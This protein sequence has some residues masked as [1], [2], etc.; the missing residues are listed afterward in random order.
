MTA[1]ILELGQAV[2]GIR[3]FLASHYGWPGYGTTVVSITGAQQI[4]V[5]G[6]K[7]Q[8][9]EQPMD[10]AMTSA[11]KMLTRQVSAAVRLQA[12]TRGLLARRRVR[13]MRD[14]QLIQPCTPSQLLQVALRCAEDLDL[15]CCVG[16]LGHAVSPTGG[17][18]AIFPAGGGWEGAS[19]HLVLHRKPS[20]ILCAVQTS[21]RLA[22]RRPGVT[23]ESA[24]CS[25]VAWSL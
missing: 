3:A 13:E 8:Q 15:V 24:P 9:I 10:I 4:P 7:L 20:A 2:A 12:A 22:G 6:E 17:G 18:H 5:T 16:D 23:S 1:A 21:S 11:G 25:A 19:L 14:L